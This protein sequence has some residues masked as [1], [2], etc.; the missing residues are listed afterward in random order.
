MAANFIDVQQLINNDGNESIKNVYEL[1][2]Q[3]KVCLVIFHH[4]VPFCKTNTYFVIVVV[5]IHFSLFLIHTF[6]INV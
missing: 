2:L 1:T 6:R 5:F 4:A 3:I